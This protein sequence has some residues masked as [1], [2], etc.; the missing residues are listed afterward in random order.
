M[1]YIEKNIL[2]HLFKWRYYIFLI[3]I[4][5]LAIIIRGLFFSVESGDYVQFLSVW[6]DTLK[7]NGGLAGIKTPIG[8]Y[9][10]PY[11]TILACLTYLPISSLVSIKLV[12]I[13]FDFFGAITAALIVKKL[14][15]TSNYSNLL[16][17]IT[18]SII[19]FL[20]TVILNGAAWGQCDFIYTSFILLS[21][22][23]L[24]NKKH[25]WS[26]FVYGIAFSFKLQAIF[27]LPLFIIIYLVNKDFSILNF[28]LIPVANLIL[29]LP[30][31]LLGYPLKNLLLVYINQTDTYHNLTMNFPN[32][33]NLMH[34]YYDLLKLPGIIFTLT[35]VGTF[36]MIVW[37]TKKR[38]SN[39]DL[40]TYSLW[41]VLT[42]TFFLPGMHDRY[43]FVAD[44]LSVIYVIINRKNF[45]LP[46]FINFTSFS[47]YI[48][49]LFGMPSSNITLLTY[50]YLIILSTFTLQIIKD[51]FS[52]KKTS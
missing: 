47:T 34:N 24:L 37:S 46:I 41:L 17:V 11:L 21:L 7:Q 4:T 51:I 20:P 45:Y 31:L 16:A 23:L 42:I 9:N 6:F 14:T 30:A 18:Y 27:I 35:V 44:I 25:F 48:I 22:Y 40:I 36:T 43:L 50:V 12:S 13:I 19:I 32:I 10:V 28:L 29:S 5:T 49:F 1:N 15:S 3:I 26:L 38:I 2:D 52:N 8:D 39:K 33:Y